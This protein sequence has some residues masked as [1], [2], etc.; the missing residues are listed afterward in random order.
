MDELYSCRV[1]TCR[2]CW[3]ILFHRGGIYEIFFPGTAPRRLPPQR[4][5]PGP[6]WSG[7]CSATWRGRDRPGRGIP[8]T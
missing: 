7:S 4:P 3:T 8:W 5:L 6:A 1:E 2:G